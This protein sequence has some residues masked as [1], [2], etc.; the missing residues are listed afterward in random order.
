MAVQSDAESQIFDYVASGTLPEPNTVTVFDQ[1][2]NVGITIDSS[3][4]VFGYMPSGIDSTGT[5]PGINTTL[6]VDDTGR[7]AVQSTTDPHAFDYKT[8]GTNNTGTVPQESTVVEFE[9][10]IQA[11]EA[12]DTYMEIVYRL[13]GQ[14]EI[15]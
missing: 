3:E 15:N 10:D 5:K 13:C 8:P 9:N 12:D 7:I 2:G 14:D 11:A 4:Q 6:M 1:T